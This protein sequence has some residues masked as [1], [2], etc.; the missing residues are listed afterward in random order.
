MCKMCRIV[1]GRGKYFSIDLGEIGTNDLKA[2]SVALSEI[3]IDD[4]GEISVG[5][6]DFGIGMVDEVGVVIWILKSV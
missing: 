5:S 4:L 6:N 1:Y 3:S 2:F